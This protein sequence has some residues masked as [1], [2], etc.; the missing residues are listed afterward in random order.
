M[1]IKHNN[2]LP[3]AH[4]HKDWQRRVKTWFNQP[5]RKLRRRLTRTRKAARAAPRPLD[6]LLRPAV[7]CP[8]IKY[9][10]KLR[11]G[12][13]F[14]LAELKAAGVSKKQ[15]LS[16]GISVDHRRRNKSEEGFNRNVQRLKQYRARL[17]LFPLRHNKP[18]K[19]DSAKEDLKLAKS[20]PIGKLLPITTPVARTKPRCLTEEEKSAGSQYQRLR[21]TWTTMKNR[22]KNE[23]KQK[24]KAEEEANKVKK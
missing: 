8:T 23:K 16:I 6:G 24:L 17:I 4:F 22:G 18:R 10:I 15:A 13:G 12:R 5:G 20:L 19:G 1:A 7:R 21:M 3:N 2:Q 9:N 11:K 14:S